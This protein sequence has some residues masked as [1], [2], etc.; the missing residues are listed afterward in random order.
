MRAVMYNPVIDGTPPPEYKQGMKVE[1]MPYGTKTLCPTG[2]T[3]PLWLTMNSYIIYVP[4]TELTQTDIDALWL[5][6]RVDVN[7]PGVPVLLSE[8]AEMRLRSLCKAG[9]I[10]T[11]GKLI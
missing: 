4:E 8:S 7:L 6:S 9:I 5:A 10:N 3:E 2:T 1:F 11:E